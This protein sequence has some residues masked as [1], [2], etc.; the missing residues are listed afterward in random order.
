MEYLDFYKEHVKGLKPNPNGTQAS[1]YC[2]FHEDAKASFSVNLETGLW[3]CHAGC[4]SGNAKQFAERLGISASKVPK[5]SSHNKIVATY[6]YK[7]EK[8]NLLYQVVRYEPK[9][10]LQ[11]RPDGKGGWI[12]NLNGTLRVLYKLPELIKSPDPVIVVEGEKDTDTIRT[13]GFNAIT[14][15]GGAGKWLDQY[16]DTLKGREVIL[17]SDNDAQGRNHMKDVAKNLRGKATSIKISELPAEFNDISEVLETIPDEDERI[18]KVSKIISEAQP[19]RDYNYGRVHQTLNKWLYIQDPR[20]IDVLLATYI[21]NLIG[22]DPIWLFLVSP[23]SGT[24]TELIRALKND[25]TYEISSLTEHALIS[26]QKGPD[27]SLLTWLTKNNKKILLVKDF[28][29]ILSMRYESMKSILADLRETYDGYIDKP[30]GTGKRF[31]WEGKLGFIAGVTSV[32]DE[33]YGVMNSL[34]GRFIQWRAPH[35]REEEMEKAR[36]NW[37]KT[38][39]MRQELN[40]CIV[41][42]LEEIEPD[43]INSINISDDFVE[44]LKILADFTAILRTEVRREYR[45]REIT[46]Y[47]DPEIPTRLF[48]CFFGMAISL[49]CIRGKGEVTEAEY[50]IVSKIARDTIPRKRDRLIEILGDA[51]GSLTTTQVREKSNLPHSTVKYALEDMAAL[52]FIEQK[53]YSSGITSPD[54]WTLTEKHREKLNFAKIYK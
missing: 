39:Q 54:C 1:G 41:G 50:K 16:S 10:F 32:I 35:D 19:L 48:Q 44:N 8:G 30:I 9:K 36:Q 17:C 27:V 29:T 20:T 7:D 24:K 13:L 37:G 45:T 53:K 5:V 12:W 34:G 3:T 38:E 49:A 51:D 42:F 46:H 21:V 23:P 18:E 31:H 26:G 47:P 43:K 40:D 14:S 28:T 11:R 15:P 22:G 33:H 52:G 25:D 4:G 6:D 2:L